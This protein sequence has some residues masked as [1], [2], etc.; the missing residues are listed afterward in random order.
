MSGLLYI[1]NIIN[2]IILLLLFKCY[3]MNIIKYY[4]INSLVPCISPIIFISFGG[5][6]KNVKKL[7][8]TH[9]RYK[10]T[11][12]ITQI[13]SFFPQIKEQTKIVIEL[14]VAS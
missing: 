3:F 10:L 14:G 8:Y 11:K 13:N 6:A 4:F 9:H 5:R 1:I 12:A 2:I 7:W